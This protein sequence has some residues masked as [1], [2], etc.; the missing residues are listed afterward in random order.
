[1]FSGPFD[2]R[3]IQS[4]EEDDECA[5]LLC[6]V[7]TDMLNDVGLYIEL[8]VLANPDRLTL[9]VT[10][11]DA[12]GCSSLSFSPDAGMVFIES[13]PFSQPKKVTGKYI[14]SLPAL[15][16]KH[17]F[18]GELGLFVSAGRIAFFRRC[19]NG[20][21]AASVECKG[22][23]SEVETG[24]WETSGYVTDLSWANGNLLMPCI[25]FRKAGAYGVRISKVCSKPP[26]PHEAIE[27]VT[28]S[29]VASACPRWRPFKLDDES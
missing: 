10:D 25:A 9:A 6:G 22:E 14:N 17:P 8:E 11:W 3:Q 20:K 18:H 27:G 1:M 21:V 29:K 19:R 12:G 7:R 23:A 13:A 16:A 5:Q 28:A 26:L 15:D 24:Q 4:V 2:G